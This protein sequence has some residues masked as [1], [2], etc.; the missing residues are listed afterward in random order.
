MTCPQNSFGEPAC[1]ITAHPDHP[2]EKFCATCNQRFV[3]KPPFEALNFIIL[4]AFLFW[5]L[6]AVIRPNPQ[7]Q[8]ESNNPEG[9]L[10]VDNP[11][12]SIQRPK[13]DNI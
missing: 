5:L 3:E 6:V 2:N 12:L 1:H 13:N 8:S 11:G 10:P 9:P 4:A 7:P